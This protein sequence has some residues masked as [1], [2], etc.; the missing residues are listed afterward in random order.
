MK[1]LRGILLMGIFCC[2]VSFVS[3][4]P[5]GGC[6]SSEDG[7]IEAGTWQ[8]LFAGGGE[9][10]PGN[11]IS[12]T[13]TTWT[14]EDAVL[15][16]HEWISQTPTVHMHKTTYVGGKLT[17][18]AGGPWET[19][20]D[21]LPYEVA[22]GDL[23]VYTTKIFD[24]NG[25]T[26]LAWTI[27]SKGAVVGCESYKVA[28]EAGYAGLPTPIIENNVMV[29]MTDAIDSMKVCISIEGK[30]NVDPDTLNLGSKG[31]WITAY[32][33]LG[34]CADLMTVDLS[35]ILLNGVLAPE[36][37][38][39]QYPDGGPVLM[40]KFSRAAVEQMVAPGMVE[41]TLTGA[42]TDG[43]EFKASDTI[44]VIERPK[45]KPVVKVK[46]AK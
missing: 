31:N 7:A 32:L 43:T 40:F 15:S 6:W 45:P 44:R 18:K 23:V 13:D 28:I 25:L 39:V 2:M 22:L 16:K 24:S 46:K 21:M 42:L 34:D 17:L 27:E 14:L 29:G 38:D 26:E 33:G 19:A 36:W 35:T 3:A 37:Y 10:Q 4:A 41:M 30:L 12:A 8:E 11:V 9:G 5:T 1:T 20:G